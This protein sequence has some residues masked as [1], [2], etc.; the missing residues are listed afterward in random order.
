MRYGDLLTAIGA[1]GMIVS[2]EDYCN[3]TDLQLLRAAKVMLSNVMC[4]NCHDNYER[5]STIRNNIQEMIGVL[6]P[7]ITT[8]LEGNDCE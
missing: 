4:S 1:R 5:M 8:L 2:E 3:L 7:K 6:E